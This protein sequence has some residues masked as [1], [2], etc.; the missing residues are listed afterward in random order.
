[1]DVN[2]PEFSDYEVAFMAVADD[3]TH[4]E[5]EEKPVLDSCR[6]Y[7]CLYGENGLSVSDEL[8]LLEQLKHAPASERFR[9][10]VEAD[11]YQDVILFLL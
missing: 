2:A 11:Y 1:M 7:L 10:D 3:A 5:A 8:A 4:W 6:M 9:L